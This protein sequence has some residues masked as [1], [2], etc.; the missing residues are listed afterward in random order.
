MAREAAARASSSGARPNCTMFASGASVPA[1]VAASTVLSVTVGTGT[2]RCV[3]IAATASL[4]S[5]PID[6]VRPFG[7]RLLVGGARVGGVLADV[8]E[9]QCRDRRARGAFPRP[10]GHESVADRGGRRAGIGGRQRQQDR[11]V[12]DRTAVE[13]AIRAFRPFRI[14]QGREHV[15]VRRVRG[16]QRRPAREGGLTFGR[17]RAGVR[18]GQRER[19]P[20]LV[21]LVANVRGQGAQG[22]QR[23]AGQEPPDLLV[24]ARD[25]RRI[26]NLPLERDARDE[27]VVGVVEAAVDLCAGLLDPGPMDR[28]ADVGR[29]GQGEQGGL[30]IAAEQQS[31]GEQDVAPL[32]E[33]RRA[34][35]VRDHVEPL[36]RG[37]EHASVEQDLGGQQLVVLAL[38]RVGRERRAVGVD[39]RRG[40][41]VARGDQPARLRVRHAGQRG[42]V[43]K[44]PDGW[45]SAAGGEREGEERDPHPRRR[46][47]S[48]PTFSSKRPSAGAVSARRQR[49]DYHRV[50]TRHRVRA[51]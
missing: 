48:A 36:E 5:G 50:R 16:E 33:Q 9:A 42:V 6:R 32:G 47:A 38:R 13:V 10:G 45:R 29:I 44:L 21:G 27:L 17:A 37:L 19:H 22:G 23:L 31:L 1:V 25:D 7:Q 34:R 3:T 49:S 12:L 28:G 18:L 11:H 14:E 20:A 26:A 30:G 8:V 43:R 40:T 51:G 2:R 39:V 46:A 15:P 35:R 4:R 24:A 41:H